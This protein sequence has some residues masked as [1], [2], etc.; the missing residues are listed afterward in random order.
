[1]NA[2]DVEGAKLEYIRHYEEKEEIK[3]DPAE[4]QKNRK[5]APTGEAAAE[6]FLGKI[7]PNS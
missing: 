1:M 5:D 6:Q 4:I 3:L 7:R 2:K